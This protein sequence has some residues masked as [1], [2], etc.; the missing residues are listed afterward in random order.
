MRN[1]IQG[2]VPEGQINY[3]NQV[4]DVPSAGIE[5]AQKK[6]EE[7]LGQL[8]AKVDNLLFVSSNEAR[9]IDTA[10]IYRQMAKEKGFEI[11][12]HQEIGNEYAKITGENEIKVLEALCLNPQNALIHSIYNSNPG[13]VFNIDWEKVRAETKMAWDEARKIV[14]SDDRGSWGANFAAHSEVVKEILLA[15]NPHEESAEDLFEKNFKDLLRLMK[16]ASQEC[17][18][19][20]VVAFGH[21]NYIVSALQKYFGE[22]GIGNCEAMSFRVTD[23]KV[24]VN[25][26]R[27]ARL[28]FSIF[29][30]N[31]NIEIKNKYYEKI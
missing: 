2:D 13:K 28:F 11:V 30:T 25:F 15:V 18:N 27:Q 19:I 1:V 9:A 21:E 17:G 7:F 29:K 14:E 26:H 16:V 24:L 12:Q 23:Q 22:H 4:F 31:L 5:L 8:D 3:D 20:V 10:N 6:A